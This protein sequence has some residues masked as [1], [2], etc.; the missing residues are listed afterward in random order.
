MLFNS[1]CF[2]LLPLFSTL[3]NGRPLDAAE[4]PRDLAPRAKSYLVINVDGGSSTPPAPEATTVIE[5]KTKTKIETIQITNSP[6]ASP[7]AT[8]I[9]SPSTSCKSSSGPQ[10]SSPPASPL[11]IETAPPSVVTV[12][13]TETAGPTEYYDN[14]LWHT[15]YRVKTVEAAVTARD[16]SM[17]LA[18]TPLPTL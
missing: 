18:P 7:S 15:S 4:K 12:I 9:A 8:P 16:N 1:L 14:G 6:T 5:E 13:I 3:S 17:Y 2:T 10:S 11:T